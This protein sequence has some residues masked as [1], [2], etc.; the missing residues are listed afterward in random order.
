LF[1][2]EIYR[3]LDEKEGV[4]LREDVEVAIKNNSGEVILVDCR[5]DD[6]GVRLPHRKGSLNLL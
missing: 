5:G 1:I 4:T 6:A 2:Q 3:S